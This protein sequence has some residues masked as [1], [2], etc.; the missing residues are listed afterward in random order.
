VEFPDGQLCEYTANLIAENMFSMCDDHGNQFLLFDAI[1][2]HVSDPQVTKKVYT[3]VNGRKF[4]KKSTAGWKMCVRWRDGSTSWEPLSDLKESYPVQVAEYAVS[5]GLEKE[6]AFVYWV[7]HVLKKRDRIIAAVNKRYHKRTHKFGIEVP[8]TV[9]RALEL[10][11]ENGNTLWQDAIAQEMKNVQIAFKILDDGK[12]VP[13]GYQYMDCHMV[14]DIKLDGFKR[15]AWFV[16][17]GHMTETPAVLTYS[18]V[19]SRDTV[20]I[21]LTIAALHDLEVKASDVQNAYLTAPCAEKIWTRLGPEFGQDQGK[22]ALIVRAL[23][24]LKSAGASFSRHLADCMETLGYKP[25]KAD[26]DLWMK[27]MVRPEDNFK[28]YA[29]ILLYVDDCLAIHHDAEGALQQID[30]FFPMK[31]GSIGDPDIYL[32]SKL[33][34]VTMDNGV[35]AWALSPTKYVQE[36]V[37]NVEAHLLERYDGRKLPRN[38][39][40]GPWPSGYVTE[41]D[42]SPELDA[43]DAAYYQSQIGVLHW[44]VELGRMDII[45]EVSLLA[46]QMAMPREGHLEAVFHIFGYLKQKHNS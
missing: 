31:A 27:P 36:A 21:A 28:Y 24:G 35:T 32:G 23:Y 38:R 41:T 25:C 6:P 3:K 33:C 34:K 37:K 39:G 8:K 29:Y 15:K 7:P 22:E 2:D 4:A 16:A 14:F 5:Q 44:M 18:S 1:V 11:R 9:K 30:K 19:V 17:G 20:R 46:S 10:D 12:A 45:T 42:E 43:E 26:S 40:S 13:P